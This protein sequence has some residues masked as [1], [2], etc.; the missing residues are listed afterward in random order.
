MHSSRFSISSA[1]AIAVAAPIASAEPATI[2]E[3][4]HTNSKG[5]ITVDASPADVYALM[6]EYASWRRFLTDITSVK[7]LSGG[8]RDAR[9]KMESRALGHEVTIA[10]DNEVDRA[11][12]FKLVDGPHGARAT[13][14]YLLVA[15]DGGKRTRIDATL[16]MDVVGVAG[17]F[18]SDK[19]IR[20]MRQAKLRADLDDVAR[21][22]RLQNRRA[23]TP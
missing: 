16:Y 21:W 6:T 1:L 2:T 7:V 4:S 9:V 20:T 5:T 10:F 11:I 12:R 19:K 22:L 15:T 23:E 17:V 3:A 13:G 18:I 14:E 8:R